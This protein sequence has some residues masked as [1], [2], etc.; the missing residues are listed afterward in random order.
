MPD[1][2]G[3]ALI[4]RVRGLTPDAGGAVPA[5][6]LTAY[7]REEDRHLALNAG[8]QNHLVKPVEP[9]D[10]AAAVAALAPEARKRPVHLGLG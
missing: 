3:Y 1:E 8:F 10:L 7:A 6:A 2:D 9:I 5:I 4:R